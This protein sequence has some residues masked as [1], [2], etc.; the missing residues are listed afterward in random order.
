MYVLSRN[1]KNIR[2][3]ICTLIDFGDEIFNVFKKACFRN[4]AK[5][6]IR[7]CMHLS[8]YII[9]AVCAPSEDSDSACAFAFR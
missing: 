3:F 9:T 1:M 4:A 8:D 5:A 6:Q 7:L 2:I